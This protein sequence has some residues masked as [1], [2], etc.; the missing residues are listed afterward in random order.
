MKSVQF[1]LALLTMVCVG[2]AQNLN[3]NGP[4]DTL[5]IT[6]FNTAELAYTLALPIQRSEELR[7]T[8][9]VNDT[10]SAGFAS[11]SVVAQYGYQTGTPVFNSSG[12]ID[13]SWDVRITIDTLDIDSFGVVPVGTVA[14]TGVVT[15]LW[16]S[17][18]DTLSVSGYAVQ[19]RRFKPEYDVLIRYW[20]QGL[21]GNSNTPLSLR[22]QHNSRE[23]E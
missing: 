20:I 4:G 18:S 17:A 19:N 13:T 23:R 9:M 8:A 14:A 11:D 2:A 1:F 10:N 5:V 6:D 12:L 22:F 16:N 3:W 15:R 7:V 21:T